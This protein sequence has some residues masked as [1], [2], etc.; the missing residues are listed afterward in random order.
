MALVILVSLLCVSAV[1]AADDAASDVI[2]D[3]DTNDVTVLGKASMV[4]ALQTVKVMR[5]F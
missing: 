1:S 4:Q 2:A 3:T 5:T